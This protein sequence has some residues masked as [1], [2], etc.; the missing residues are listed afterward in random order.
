[1]TTAFVLAGGGSLGAVQVGMLQ[2]LGDAGV[3]PDVLIGTS[4]GAMNAAWVG[5]HG[6][7]RES[8]DGLAA[9]WEGLRRHDVF[10]VD[11]GRLARGL[12]GA[13]AALCSPDRLRGLVRANAGYDDLAD[14]SIPVEVLTTDLLTGLPVVL[15]TGPV[16]DA[17]VASAAVPGI[18]PPTV[19]D[20]RHLVDGGVA[21]HGGVGR[22]VELGADVVYV[23]P[24][25]AACALAHPPRTAI[26]VALHALTLVIQRRLSAEV[27]A[28]GPEPGS[29]L[30]V[31]PPLCPLGIPPTDFAQAAA[32]VRRGRE[33]STRWLATGGTELPAQ[34]RFLRLH[35][36]EP[37]SRPDDPH[38]SA[39]PA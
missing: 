17:V 27:A 34:H 14:A 33:A 18:F 29:V 3:R 4:A 30:R 8:L 22:A 12:L 39:R 13:S 23:L 6:M 15:S 37:V 19:V 9:L 2:A 1:M 35:S 32:L 36:H 10:P 11:P 24:T 31:L 26:G 7:S 38:R 21:G 5:G 28:L 16:A 25:G 20:R